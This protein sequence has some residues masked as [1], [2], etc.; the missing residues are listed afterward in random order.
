M[1]GVDGGWK[2]KPL[3]C[4]AGTVCLA[5]VRKTAAWL[6]RRDAGQGF[7]GRGITQPAMDY[8]AFVAR[9]E[10][11]EA[12]WDFISKSSV[13]DHWCFEDSVLADGRVCK[14]TGKEMEM[15]LS[16]VGCWKREEWMMAGRWAS[17]WLT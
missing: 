10:G 12:Q 15:R 1:L 16:F 13:I 5:Q 3:F 4:S 2:L 6:S 9:H 17:A 11:I 14:A 8:P 7:M